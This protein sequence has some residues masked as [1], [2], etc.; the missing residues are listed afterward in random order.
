MTMTK[1]LS[2]NLTRTLAKALTLPRGAILTLSAAACAYLLMAP[3]AT[4]ALSQFECAAPE[5]FETLAGFEPDA[6]HETGMTALRQQASLALAQL[7]G[8]IG[9]N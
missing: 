9:G 8:R 3:G 4:P 5:Y 2:N 1:N 7:Q 6:A